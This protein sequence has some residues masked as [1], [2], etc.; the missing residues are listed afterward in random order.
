[1]RIAAALSLSAVVLCT[2]PTLAQVTGDNCVSLANTIGAGYSSSFS[3][4][5]FNALKYY[6][7]CEASQSNPSAGLNLG[8]GAFSLGAKYGDQQQ[9]EFCSKSFD[10]YDIS[11]QDYNTTKIV[12]NQ[13]L[14][15]INLC[16]E[17]ASRQW[18]INV[19]QIAKD[20]IS[21]AIG[22]LSTSGGDLVGID[23]LPPNSM[24]CEG[25]PTN[26][27]FRTTSTNYVSMTCSRQATV[28]IV[29]GVQ[30]S[31]APDVTLN[32]RLADGPFPI[33]L[34]GYTS[35]AL[36]AIR[37]KIDSVEQASKKG[38]DDLRNALA[39]ATWGGAKDSPPFR[40]LP[41]AP[42]P[43]SCD[44]GY[45]VV[46]MKAWAGT[47]SLGGG[48]IYQIQLDCRKLNLP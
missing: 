35:S 26:F 4:R 10:K 41:D 7:N 20:A 38:I 23:I 46:G 31:S 32:L 5:Q 25:A 30:V 12:F 24:T 48:N 45:Y 40:G 47:A 29:D 13:A 19:R 22:N 16:L 37:K 43:G 28:Q 34:P 1:M 33:A 3:D 9:K 44:A 36:D 27:P 21:L 6:A 14:A 15:T 42:N 8:F 11:N 17:K 18:A 39:S 2:S